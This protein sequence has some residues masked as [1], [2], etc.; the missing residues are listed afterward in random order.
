MRPV[1]NAED[2]VSSCQNTDT[3]LLEYSFSLDGDTTEFCGAPST[4]TQH[5]VLDQQKECDG[6]CMVIR[7]I[8]PVFTAMNER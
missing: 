2:H 8:V 7:Y 4:L 3:W 1:A 6:L 5:F